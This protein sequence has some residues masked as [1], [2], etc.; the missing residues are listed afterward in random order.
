MT[1]W[2]Y[3]D[4]RRAGHMAHLLDGM[5]HIVP[6]NE[7]KTHSVEIGCW[8]SPRVVWSPEAETCI[9]SHRAMRE[10]SDD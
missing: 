10:T 3:F 9:V 1:E 8:C 6:R 5:F 2:V 7:G 4:T